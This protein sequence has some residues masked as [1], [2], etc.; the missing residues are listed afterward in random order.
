M[1]LDTGFQFGNSIAGDKRVQ[2]LVRVVAVLYIVY[3]VLIVFIVGSRI[4]NIVRVI[5]EVQGLGETPL[6]ALI[7]LITLGFI[8]LAL[9]VVICILVF[10]LFKQTNRVLCLVLSAVLLIGFPVGTVLGIFT[11]ILLTRAPVKEQFG[12]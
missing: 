5:S 3:A 9:F 1:N 4:A 10:F 2:K 11:L 12:G 7:P 6:S 8:G